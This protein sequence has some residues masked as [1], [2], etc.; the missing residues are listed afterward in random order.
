MFSFQIMSVKRRRKVQK[1]LDSLG[2]GG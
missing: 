2:N 1:N